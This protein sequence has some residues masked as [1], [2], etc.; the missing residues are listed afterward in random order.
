MFLEAILI[1]KRHRQ[2]G[3]GTEIPQF[4]PGAEPRRPQ[5]PE[6]CYVMRLIKTIRRKKQVHAD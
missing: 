6:E 1:W 2:E 3:L 4:G 5:K